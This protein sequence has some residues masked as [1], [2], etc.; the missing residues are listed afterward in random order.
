MNFLP[1]RTTM[2]GEATGET[3]LQQVRTTV[4]DADAHQ[5]CPFQKIVEGARPDRGNSQSPLYNVSFQFD[6]YPQ[7]GSFTDTLEASFE[8]PHREISQLDLRFV[9]SETGAGTV[10]SCEYA[11][12]LFDVQTIRALLEALSGILEKLVQQPETRLHEF[13]VSD[14]LVRRAPPE[15]VAITSTFTAEP[16]EESIAFWSQELDAAC[17]TQFAPYGQVFQQ[18]L[19]PDSLLA[20]NQRGLNVVLV[21]LEDWL[22][23]QAHSPTQVHSAELQRKIEELGDALSTAAARTS[24]PCLVCICPSSPLMMSDPAHRALHE[25]MERLLASSLSHVPGV[26]LKTAN[27]LARV[28]P[29]SDYYDRHGDELGHVPY[30]R[31]FFTALGTSIIRHLASIKRAPTKVI[32]LDCDH[33]LWKGVCGEDGVEGI[34]I[35]R[36]HKALQEFMV[37]QQNAGRLI[38]LCS[39]NQEADVFEVFDRRDDMPLRRE[40]IVSWRI[41]WQPKSQ[42][43]RSL[44]EE[45]QLGL[46]SFVFLDDSPL[47]CAEVRANCPEVLTLQLPESADQIP[48]FLANVWAFDQARITSEDRKR[49]RLYQ[50]NA[51][52]ERLREKSLT[53][54]EFIADLGLDVSIDR[55]SP[56]QVPRVSQL[57][58]RTNQFN[59]NKVGRSEGELETISRDANADCLTVNVSDRFGDYGLV[60]VAICES[61]ASR[62]N[63]DA[64]LLS[65]RVLGRGVEHRLLARLGDL[66]AEKGLE[67]VRIPLKRTDRNQP[68]L[69][70][71]TSVAAR[72]GRPNGNGIEFVIPVHEAQDVKFQPEIGPTTTLTEETTER[73]APALKNGWSTARLSEMSAQLL[74]VTAIVG[75]IDDRRRG[76]VGSHARA[77]F[78]APRTETERLIAGVWEHLLGLERVGVRDDFFAIGGH[79]LLATQVMSRLCDVFQ[80]NLPLQTAFDAPTVAALAR[81]VEGAKGASLDDAIPAVRRSPRGADLPLSF[82]QERLWFLDRFEPGSSLFNSPVAVRLRGRPNTPAF[83]QALQAIATRHEV[84]RTTFGPDGDRAMQVVDPD[85]H[86]DLRLIDVSGCTWNEILRLT[87]EESQRPFDL[88]RGP[89]FRVTLLRLSSDEHIVLLNLHH[90]VSDGWSA[91]VLMNEVSTLYDAYSRGDS[92]SL[93]D[94]PVQY[95]DFAV[96]Q[97]QWLDGA[98]L[99]AQLSYWRERLEGAPPTLDLP[100]DG[101]RPPVRTYRG[102]LA[103]RPLPRALCDRLLRVARQE[104]VTTFMMF[105][106][107]FQVLLSKYVGRGDVVVGTTI[108]NRR[109]PELEGLIGLFVN[110]LALRLDVS[111]NPS[112]REALRR[113]REVTLGAYAHQDLP[114]EKL[115]EALQPV[116][117]M[118]R[119]PVFQVSIEARDESVATLSL[120]GL[121]VTREP[122]TGVTAKCDV[123]LLVVERDGAPARLDIEYNTDIFQASS[124]D[125]LLEQFEVLLQG[126]VDDP[127]QPVANLPLLGE[128]ERR[129]LLVE[130]NDTSVDWPTDECLN[131]LIEAQVLKTPDAVAVVVDDH[132]LTYGELNWKA[133]QLA[134]HLRSLGVGPEARVGL[135][136]NRSIELVVGVLGVL[137]SGAAYVP[138]DPAY[139][140][141][142]LAFILRDSGASVVLSDERL[143]ASLPEHTA[144]VVFLDS[145]V[146]IAHVESGENLERQG[147]SQN[148]SHVIYTS[149]STGRPKGVA[150]EQ[151]SVVTLVRWSHENYSPEELA[152]VLAATSICFDLSVWELFVPLS[153][154]GAVILAPTA[155]ELPTLPSAQ[156]VTLINT[157]PSA[158]AEL[159][160]TGGIPSSVRTV[161][162]AGEP[163][164][165]DLSDALYATGSIEKVCDL[166]GPSE[167]TTY[168]TFARRRIGDRATI[169]RP[170]ANTRVYVGQLG[171]APVPIGVAGELYLSGAG[172]ARGYLD[173]PDLTAERFLPDAL[174]SW[175]GERIYRTG[176]LARWGADGRL[177]FLGRID[178]QVKIRGFRIELGEIES[179][180]RDHP[181]VREAIVMARE[182]Q[183]GTR[184]LVAYLA[185]DG[186]P[187]ATDLRDHLQGRLP[188][189]MVPAAFVTLEALPLLPNGKIARRALPAP[190][191]TR[192]E[193]EASF[194]AARG[195]VERG[196]AEIWCQVLG[197]ER[198]GVHDNFFELGGHSL[199]AT[200]VVSRLR[201]A[202]GTEIPLRRVFE[203]PTVAELAKCLGEEHARSSSAP[204]E[205]LPPLERTRRE[206]PLP[207]SFAQQRL[208]FLEQMEPGNP[209]YNMPAALRVNGEV[210]VAALERAF[211]EIV[212]RHEVLQAG[213]VLRQ[214]QPVQTRVPSAL[215]L[216]I[217]DLSSLDEATQE[218]QVR[219]LAALDARRSFDLSAGQVLRV[220][221]LACGE[222]SH[223]ILFAMHHIVSDGWSLAIV[224]RELSVL[225]TAF[226]EGHP[227]P[228]D[229]LPV[230]YADFAVWQRGWLESDGLKSQLAYWRARLGGQLP[231][232][233]IRTDRPRPEIETFRGADETLV[234]PHALAG[235]LNRL[236]KQEH[237]TLFMTLVA[238][239]KTLLY[240][241]VG[242]D[243]VVVGTDLAGRNRAELEGLIGFFVNLLVLRSDLSGNPTFRELL[244]RVRETAMGAFAHQDVPF[245]RLV[246]ELRPKR[247]RSRTP[248]FQMLF[249]MENVPLETLHLPGLTMTPMPSQADT[250]R[251]DLA[252]FVREQHDGIVTKWTYKTDLFDRV[253]IQRLANQYLALLENIA[254]APDTRLNDLTV[255]TEAEMRDRAVEESRHRET[256]MSSLVPGRR[257]AKTLPEKAADVNRAE[258]ED[259]A[260]AGATK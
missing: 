126:I 93:T 240:R 9:A 211:A 27:D 63:V 222:A 105:L 20:T 168:S 46:D 139:P 156:R 253:T 179:A 137:K 200:K 66:A 119:T 33:T 113:V 238:A 177:D 128:T 117:D 183:P 218:E 97:R 78:V 62:L 90:I 116:R 23:A 30:T 44:A 35:D 239:Y 162:L 71:L 193:L 32:V 10:L 120:R 229:E 37:A 67:H 31:E 154:G 145:T 56:Q 232:L 132:Q 247:H 189:Y 204:G 186:P 148:L 5:D 178:H 124:M 88:E 210:R 208:W 255:Q 225:Y 170:L 151:R 17:R 114:F 260:A 68:A 144:C 111:D 87:L 92:S 54:A 221:L 76:R 173:R 172:L 142:R 216:R 110:T 185:A 147:A 82:A 159:L 219:R 157:V 50:E 152:G 70:F 58:Q 206:G 14:T 175:A 197:L 190:D 138:M 252:L 256:R 234:I 103:S 107:A 241:H 257:R 12:D 36:G 254:A 115:V 140:A 4:L 53:F 61:D 43:V 109:R 80:V 141:S 153:A 60:G 194:V 52:R 121:E 77:E 214:G 25:R 122:I 205:E 118:S 75:A 217:V 19:A 136:L 171:H 102:A 223:T 73:V 123:S 129:Q 166:Y 155:L 48:A 65:C 196:L 187:T 180:L 230:Q 164:T 202:F 143:A 16:V 95:G 29:V 250:A 39:K 21:R 42:N 55:M 24:T 182:D 184:R 133:N 1:L 169:G 226:R 176:D 248:L 6:N 45:L 165:S 38:C 98:V 104:R 28:Y 99:E 26:T 134:R 79:S 246:E 125:R 209:Y 191:Q 167:D 91:G 188:G 13:L 199:L 258:A 135:C 41:N 2:S 49:T 146:Q 8:T 163:L 72:Y 181:A 81:V 174:G 160:R 245:D 86:P 231:T 244:A 192:P 94:L 130:W 235:A 101:V 22:G 228:L 57:T 100:T 215:D 7:S 242:E 149:G 84:L 224:V 249:V 251:F 112:F 96:W 106:A 40:H 212:R 201:A 158:I 213:Y 207:L 220:T 203:N 243:D 83:Y 18:L 64:L 89:L 150:I 59:V 195:P 47:E 131:E 236:S 69:E 3:I 259:D 227:S 15:T 161:N 51:Q 11:T 127:G 34:S 74:D 85:G 108:A 237:A 198:V 233:D